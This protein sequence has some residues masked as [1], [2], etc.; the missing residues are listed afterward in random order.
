MFGFA[1]VV[2]FSLLVWK[3]ID[4]DDRIKKLEK[5]I[6]KPMEFDND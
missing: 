2:L 1:L 3:V 4:L 6:P 5:T